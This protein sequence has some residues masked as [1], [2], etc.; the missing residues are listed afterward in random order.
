MS[1]NGASAPAQLLGTALEIRL[2]A[3]DHALEGSTI[4]FDALSL[5]AQGGTA[6]PVLPGWYIDDVEIIAL[7]AQ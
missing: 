6:P 7:P 5:T 4:E 3:L 1:Y 2:L